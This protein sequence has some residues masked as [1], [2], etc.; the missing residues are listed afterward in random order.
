MSAAVCVSSDNVL[1]TKVLGTPDG[2]IFMGGRDGSHPPAPNHML[3]V[4]AAAVSTSL[5][6]LWSQ[7]GMALLVRPGRF[8][9]ALDARSGPRLCCCQVNH[10][11]TGSAYRQGK[12]VVV[13]TMKFLGAGPLANKVERELRVTVSNTDIEYRCLAHRMGQ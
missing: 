1:M 8:P 2:R 3:T 12:N 7:G 13:E 6:M 5:C 4:L 11:V 10:S 9:P